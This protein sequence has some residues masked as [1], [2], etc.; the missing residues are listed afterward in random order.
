MRIHV[1]KTHLA[2]LTNS[3]QE[4]WSTAA[5]RDIINFFIDLGKAAVEAADAIG[6]LPTILLGLTAYSSILKTGVGSNGLIDLF[7]STTIYQNAQKSFNADKLVNSATSAE[8]ALW[9]SYGAF[10]GQG[11]SVFGDAANDI[12]KANTELTKM[13]KITKAGISGFEH[14][15]A[16]IRDI[17]PAAMGSVAALTTILSI[18]I[19]LI[20]H[21]EQMKK[22]QLDTARITGETFLNNQDGI[23]QNI[24]RYEELRAK[25]QEG[26][27]TEQEQIQIKEEILNIQKSI[28]E[29]YDGQVKGVDL[30]NGELEKQKVILDEIVS[31]EANRIWESKD[32]QDGFKIATEEMTKANNFTIRSF[33]N[34][35]D[36]LDEILKKYADFQ[37][38]TTEGEY[39]EGT[40]MFEFAFGSED[41]YEA[42]DKV[43]AAIDE[44]EQYRQDHL[45]DESA[46]EYADTMLEQLRDQSGIIEKTLKDYEQIYL[47]GLEIELKANLNIENVR[48]LTNLDGSQ[49]TGYQVYQN[50]QSS[51]SDLE[52]AYASG[53]TKKIDEAREAFEKADEAKNK[54]LSV[55]NNN[56]FN[57][58]FNQI[59][60]STID[61]KNRVEDLRDVLELVPQSTIESYNKAKEAGNEAYKQLGEFQKVGNVDNGD[62]PFIFWDDKEIKKQEKA[63]KSWGETAENLKGVYGGSGEFDGIEIAFTPIIKGAD[64]QG[65]LLSKDTLYKYIDS[66]I[67]EAGEGW[68]N[69]ELLALD[70]KGMTVDGIQISNVIADIGDTAIQTGEKMHEWQ[71]ASIG[72][73]ADFKDIYKEAL[74]Q[75]MSLDEYMSKQSHLYVKNSKA[76]EKYADKQ[77]DI[78]NSAKRVKEL[79]LDKI[80]V[81]SVFESGA[82]SS[83]DYADALY[84]LMNAMGYAESESGIFIDDMV[85]L[86]LI[87]GDVTDATF[88]ASDA[89]NQFSQEI[90]AAIENVSKLN[91]V[92]SES[93][94]GANIS[95]QN[96]DAFKEMFGNDYIYALERSANGYHI[97]TE[98]LQTLIDKQNALTNSDY[99][100]TLDAQY[101]ALKRCNDEIIKANNAQKDTSGLLAQRQ[102]ILQRIQDTQDLMMAY[103]ASTSAFQTWTNAQSNGNEYDMYDKI[104][105][106]YDTVKDLIDR[107]WSGDDTVR[108]YLDLIYGES[109]DAFTASGEE[110]AE[111]FD[112][113][114]KKI[115]GTSFSI[116]DFFQFDSSGKITSGGIFNFFDA[117]KEKQ[118]ELDL[119]DKSKWIKDDGTY[120]FG[121]GRDREAAEALGIDVEFFQSMLR[122]AVSAGFKLNLDQPMWAMDELKDKAAQAQEELGGFNN[123]NFEE[124]Y[125]NLDDEDAYETISGHIDDV[126]S[127]I[128]D[129]ENSDLSP[130]LKTQQIEQAQDMLSYLVALE[131]EAADRG[132]IDLKATVVGSAT[133]KISQLIEETDELPDVLKQYNWDEITDKDGLQKARD[134]ITAEVEGGKIDSSSAEA[135]LNILDQALVE[136]GL[137]DKYE[138]N[139]TFKGN[140]V[141]AYNEIAQAKAGLQEYLSTVQQIEKAH[142]DLKIDFSEDPELQKYLSIIYGENTTPDLKLA[143][144]I[145][146]DGT[147]EQVYEML[148]EGERDVNVLL[149]GDT[150]QLEKDID[151]T[152]KGRTVENN[153]TT[154]KTEVTNKEEHVSAS[155]IIDDENFD[156]RMALNEQRLEHLDSSKAEVE[157][158]A[159]TTSYDEKNSETEAKIK[160]MNKASA[161]IIFKGDNTDA[162]NKANT[163]ISYKNAIDGATATINFKSNG[164]DT[165]NSDLSNAI[166]KVNRLDNR[167]STVA[168]RRISGSVEVNGTAH[169]QGTAFAK[170]T[171]VSGHAFAGGNWG[172]PKNQT[173]LV[174]EIGEE[175]IV[176]DGKWFI[177]ND[178]NAGFTQLRKGDVVFNS[179]QSKELLEK[180]YVTGK[181]RASTVGFSN[182]TAYSSGTYNGSTRPRVSTNSS[183]NKSSGSS[184]SGRSGSGGSGRSG[185]NNNSSSNDAKETKNTLDEVEILIARI[186]RQISNLDKTIGNTYKNWSTRNKA[187]TSNLKKVATEIKDQNKAYTTYINKANSIGLPTAWKKKIQSGAFRIEDVVEKAKESGDTSDSLWDKINQYKQW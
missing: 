107:G 58:L 53:N 78:Y 103:Q 42:K 2:Q 132:E 95:T 49:M 134:F 127:F 59:S 135:F 71:S 76:V 102:G 23:N 139:P 166:E 137:I 151:K 126:Y 106:G 27:L 156:Q 13:E 186:E 178:G 168:N 1:N 98:N 87:H 16:S 148:E 146:E 104:A 21:F 110:C 180:G 149:K 72:Y 96:L 144:G 109:F 94:S 82:S 48:D 65:K 4:M 14:M 30:V 90:A 105:N 36:E 153:E 77:D 117:L 143:F 175:I 28:N 100:K 55:G 112:N 15:K 128:Q 40:N 116:R 57:S 7:K 25:M 54:F 46:T 86:G 79:N 88:T 184:G 44:V 145:D 118:D 155:L 160:K 136:L 73:I 19:A 38:N 62:R 177:A 176:R 114:D 157:I 174:N 26:N 120:D 170:G 47:Q 181:K 152:I 171:V 113:L 158:D 92:L 187:I 68:T 122:A 141:E 84:D 119:D 89:Y 169:V 67:S 81:K 56:Q 45:E 142:P 172:V 185:G 183:K 50:Y 129:V 35:Q 163:T 31:K 52:S 130:E 3:W 165:L 138:A 80:D 85:T 69:E 115:E 99:Q 150:T 167:I 74:E 63:I 41:I 29:S 43:E 61:A 83:A 97:N 33:R 10:G 154:T 179:E 140:T 159:N 147:S 75:G 182:G 6:I 20:N 64:G 101:D 37:A 51:I 124:L 123:I 12:S 91:T 17:V 18:T 11:A 9:A 125:N 70:A 5:N 108:S 121:F 22:E 93:V 164:L 173:A 162:V 8:D 39:G 131:R 133:D 66:L 34:G 111:M 60:T 24:A 161:T 32:F